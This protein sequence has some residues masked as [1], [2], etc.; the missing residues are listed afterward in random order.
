M[1]ATPTAEAKSQPSESVSALVGAQ[2]WSA[3]WRRE[4]SALTVLPGWGCGPG[5]THFLLALLIG[6]HRLIEAPP[7]SEVRNLST[8]VSP[9]LLTTKSESTLRTVTNG[10]L[11]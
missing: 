10:H 5:A 4:L 2:L 1:M 6:G 7:C 8:N 3:L 9:T 11:D